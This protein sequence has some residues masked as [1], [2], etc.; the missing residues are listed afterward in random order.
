MKQ[1]I[2][3][4]KESKFSVNYNGIELTEDLCVRMMDI[5][6]ELSPENQRKFIELSETNLQELINFCNEVKE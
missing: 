6:D 5:H 4:L 1:L 2:N 3:I